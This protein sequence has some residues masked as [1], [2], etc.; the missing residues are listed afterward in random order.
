MVILIVGD[1]YG[2]LRYI[3]TLHFLGTFIR[4]SVTVVV[5][6]IYGVVR[7]TPVTDFIPIPT[8]VV[9]PGVVTCY[10][11]FPTDFAIVITVIYG[12]FIRC[13]FCCYCCCTF[14]LFGIVPFGIR[15]IRC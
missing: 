8:F 10:S 14:H 7:F 4:C 1:C 9:I 15:C 6:T 2:V 12:T 13:I 11:A 5:V 3:A